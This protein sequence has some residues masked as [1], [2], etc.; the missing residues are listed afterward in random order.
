MSLDTLLLL[1]FAAIAALFGAVMFFGDEPDDA[2]LQG[3][4]LVQGDKLEAGQH[5]KL[6]GPLKASQV[7]TSPLGE[8]CVFHRTMVYATERGRD[9]ETSEVELWKQKLWS[10]DLSVTDGY[11]RVFL[12]LTHAEVRP[13]ARKELTFSILTDRAQLPG[14]LSRDLPPETRDQMTRLVVETIAPGEKA[15]V[16]G[17]VEKVGG[18]VTLGGTDMVFT[19]ES[20][21]Q[22]ASRKR[23]H[24]LYG[25]GL[26]ALAVLLVIGAVVSR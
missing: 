21:D 14:S 18:L 7:L 24:Q 23:T 11:A 8:P 10:D 3:V 17:H 19:T 2:R 1:A 12:D 15:I 16:A 13:S 9:A 6:V 4:P 20:D 22:R 26:F 25:V 5:A